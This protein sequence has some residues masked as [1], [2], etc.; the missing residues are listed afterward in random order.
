MN[1]VVEVKDEK[2][3]RQYSSPLRT[4]MA[5]QTR[6]RVTR[7]AL[8]EFLAQGYA[9]A[10]IDRIAAR[11]GVSRPTVFAVGPKAT[12]LK[13]ARDRAIAGDDDPRHIGARPDAQAIASASGPEEALRRFARM[14]AGIAQRFA[15]LNEVLRQGA[16]TEPEVARIWQTSEQER[17]MAARA[18]I[19]TV[20]AKGTLKP[21]LDRDAAAD[22]LWLFMAPEQY[23]RLVHERSWAFERYARWYADTLVDLLLP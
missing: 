20:A 10:T 23:H 11:A 8:E 13:L 16:A 1:P 2:R 19:E 6:H 3:R 18:T 5:E 22:I 14:S 7:A 12:L 4:E 21:G 15:A 9:G 17:L